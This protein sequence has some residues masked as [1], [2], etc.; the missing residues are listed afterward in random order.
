ML[1]GLAPLTTLDKVRALDADC[2]VALD[3]KA[4]LLAT[5]PEAKDRNGK[6]ACELASRACKQTKSKIPR[7]LLI[8]AAAKAECGDFQEASRIASQ[9]LELADADSSSAATIHAALKVFEQRKPLRRS[10][11]QPAG[12]DIR[13]R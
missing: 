4:H 9:A 8:L 7:N 6:E 2:L 1:P 10:A 3:N 11:E 5:A 13:I 12:F